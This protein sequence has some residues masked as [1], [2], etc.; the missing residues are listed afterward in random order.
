[1]K[2]SLLPF[3]VSELN[4]DPLRPS[5]QWSIW[6][7]ETTGTPRDSAEATIASEPRLEALSVCMLAVKTP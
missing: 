4:E 3:Q 6:R 1:M 2:S 7:A 5:S